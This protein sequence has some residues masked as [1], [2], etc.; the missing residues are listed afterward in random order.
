MLSR[1]P[2]DEAPRIIYGFAPINRPT[3]DSLG[4]VGPT[5]TVGKVGVTFTPPKARRSKLAVR[6]PVRRQVE[7]ANQLWTPPPTKRKEGS[8]AAF[9]NSIVETDS[10]QAKRPKCK[11]FEAI[12]N[13]T[14][15]RMMVS[16]QAQPGA[17]DKQLRQERDSKISQSSLIKL[18]TFRYRVQPSDHYQLAPSVETPNW[19]LPDLDRPAD[20]TT[21][22]MSTADSIPGVNSRLAAFSAN[23][24]LYGTP[25]EHSPI[26]SSRIVGLEISSFPS[27]ELGRSDD[28]GEAIQLT[29]RQRVS[30]DT[31]SGAEAGRSS[32]GPSD[33]Q[34]QDTALIEDSVNHPATHRCLGNRIAVS[35]DNGHLDCSE[36]DEDVEKTSHQHSLTPIIHHSDLDG[37]YRDE[38]ETMD[39][40]E[41]TASFQDQ[42]HEAHFIPTSNSR[43]ANE[44]GWDDPE[45]EFLLDDNDI[46]ALLDLPG[47][48]G[49]VEPSSNLHLL[50]SQN[51]E[52]DDMRSPEWTEDFKATS[53][54]KDIY[55]LKDGVYTPV[56][57]ATTM[58]TLN[59]D[60]GTGQSLRDARANIGRKL[61]TTTSQARRLSIIDDEESFDLDEQDETELADLTAT[62]SQERGTS[63]WNIA[64]APQTPPDATQAH[65]S[66]P[67][68]ARSTS[69][70]PLSSSS[71]QQPPSPAPNRPLE[72][73]VRRPFPK[74]VRDRS[75]VVELSSSG[76]LRTCFRIGEALNAASVA[77][78]TGT[79][80]IIELFARVNASTR[81]REG[82]KQHIVFAD[83]FHSGR[84]PFLSG[85]YELWKDGGRWEENSRP[86][87]EEHGSGKICRAV[88]R[89]RRDQDTKRWKMAVLNIWEATWGDVA[90]AKGVVCG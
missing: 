81:E 51:H 30:P 74:P 32:I 72:P 42:S 40:F 58:G 73:F 79:D 60:L 45:D 11:G 25:V 39:S 38:G 50:S 21:K 75:P 1:V 78:R 69:V 54:G 6:T 90:W 59:S 10:P 16:E 2:D 48:Q 17:A 89:L 77:V 71:P 13:S 19:Q 84:P 7:A 20:H 43:S 66:A 35:L 27:A 57:A 86:F 5:P 12:A 87:L 63:L 70:L 62:M 22:L 15:E 56:E 24:N 68:I 23:V 47:G 36:R 3:L 46:D 82:Y 44:Q 37:I 29:T 80:V 34:V 83:L 41:G 64:I 28:I 85:T 49:V 52:V 67:E 53:A 55:I 4:T 31:G 9:D 8:R 76:V 14:Q 33:I 61:K 88:G 65:T 18:D 26:S